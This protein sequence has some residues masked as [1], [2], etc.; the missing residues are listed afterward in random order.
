M[1]KY[2]ESQV[3]RHILTNEK[4]VIIRVVNYPS[5]TCYYCSGEDYTNRTFSETELTSLAVPLPGNLG[6]K[7]I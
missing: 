1:N 3:V 2:K 5:E 6:E 4:F 7:S